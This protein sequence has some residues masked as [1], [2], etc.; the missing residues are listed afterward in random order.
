MAT[1]LRNELA[2]WLHNI[3]KCDRWFDISLKMQDTRLR[4][5]N[6]HEP[7]CQ[8]GFGEHAM[9]PRG[10]HDEHGDARRYCHGSRHGRGHP[11]RS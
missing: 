2:M 10:P 11:R 1:F 7:R 6:L 8:T 4:A 5:I 9:R 3:T